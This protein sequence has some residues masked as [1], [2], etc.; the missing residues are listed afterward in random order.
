MYPPYVLYI[1]ENEG[2]LNVEPAGNDVLGILKG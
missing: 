2:L 1:R